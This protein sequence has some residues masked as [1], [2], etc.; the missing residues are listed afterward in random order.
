MQEILFHESCRYQDE[1]IRF[2]YFVKPEHGQKNV[3]WMTVKSDYFSPFWYF[4]K[5]EQLKRGLSWN[6]EV[7]QET[8]SDA[9]LSPSSQFI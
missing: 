3:P 9:S 4:E 1:P 2:L 8:L 7:T 5:R 6:W